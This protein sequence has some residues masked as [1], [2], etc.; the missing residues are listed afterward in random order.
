MIDRKQIEIIANEA[1]KETEVFLVDVLVN[2]GNVIQVF[3]DHNKG[4]SLDDCAGLH[5]AIEEHLDREQEDFELQVSSPGLG[6]PIRVF[7]QYIKE[8]GQK[9][10]IVFQDGDILKGTLIEARPAE[11]GKE[12]ELIIR[13]I[14]TKR[15]AAQEEPITVELSRVKSARVLID[16]KLV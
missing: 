16:F 7:P 14:G 13:Q 6:Q 10:E 2:R 8:T 3:I 1:L 9:L 12:A 4:V 15:K 5:R 11:E